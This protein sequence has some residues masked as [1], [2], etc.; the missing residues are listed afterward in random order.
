MGLCATA[1]QVAALRQH[2]HSVQFPLQPTLKLKFELTPEQREIAELL[3]AQGMASVDAERISV[4]INPKKADVLSWIETAANKTNPAGYL[5]VVLE[6]GDAR[7]PAARA[8]RTKAGKTGNYKPGSAVAGQRGRSN[9]GPIDFA[10]Y[11]PGGKYGYLTEPA[12]AS[13]ADMVAYSAAIVTEAETSE[14]NDTE[15]QASMLSSN[16]NNNTAQAQA[17]S[18]QQL[19]TTSELAELWAEA[20][21]VAFDRYG[22]T[23]L[24]PL[25]ANTWLELADQEAPRRGDEDTGR[26]GDTRCLY[27]NLCFSDIGQER[28]LRTADL[29][30]IRLAVR[31]LLSYRCELTK[32][33][34]PAAASE[35]P[36]SVTVDD[37]AALI[38]PTSAR[39]EETL[40]QAIAPI[41]PHKAIATTTAV[42][43]HTGIVVVVEENLT[44]TPAEVASPTIIDCTL[45]VP[46]ATP[47]TALLA[48]LQA[49]TSPEIG[50]KVD[51][52]Y[53]HL[54]E[55]EP[56]QNSR[57][58]QQPVEIG[59]AIRGSLHQF[60]RRAAS[61]TKS[62][63]VLHINN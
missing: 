36:N 7:P 46:V 50:P 13:F 34:A 56:R 33:L 21:Q 53:S 6:R 63:K 37:K 22:L 62:G 10:K 58:E 28:A 25:L 2:L 27:L 61:N 48:E 38:V 1:A 52:G 35:T 39:P 8:E 42:Q 31:N 44:P 51:K 14:T 60:D 49:A 19:P 32:L 26:I 54:V 43:D 47:A 18:I 55:W 45:P 5:R 30:S 20:Q 15:D 57:Q 9:E 12:Q 59:R 4:T 3:T 23:K 24:K 17:A 40:G 41:A 11:G 16:G 29:S